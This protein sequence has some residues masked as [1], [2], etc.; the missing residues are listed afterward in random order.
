MNFSLTL[1][2][3]LGEGAFGM[4]IKGIA[5]GIAGRAGSTTVAVKMLKGTYFFYSV[6]KIVLARRNLVQLAKHK[7]FLTDFN[8]SGR[9]DF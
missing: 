6:K 9:Y 2:P 3:M 1:G 8:F 4:V 5:F 7:S